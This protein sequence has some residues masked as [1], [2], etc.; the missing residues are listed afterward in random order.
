VVFQ[1]RPEPIAEVSKATS[2][3]TVVGIRIALLLDSVLI[4]SGIALGA[5]A[6]WGVKALIAY[7]WLN[8]CAAAVSGAASF[9]AL[10]EIYG[11]QLVFPD[12]LLVAFPVLLICQVIYSVVLLQALSS[13]IATSYFRSVGMSPCLLPEGARASLS[14]MLERTRTSAARRGLAMV[15]GLFAAM[16]GCAN[17]VA[18]TRD[19]FDA[20]DW[21]PM[22]ALHLIGAGFC[23]LLCAIC[24]DNVFDLQNR[25]R[26]AL[27]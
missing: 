19:H 12:V 11:G 3:C 23:V 10:S 27:V 22:A 14:R 16:A 8:L 6:R 5:G 1:G 2:L 13:K 24:R 20:L 25:R 17:L 18:L 15:L 4:I 9:M 21:P 7:A 26:P